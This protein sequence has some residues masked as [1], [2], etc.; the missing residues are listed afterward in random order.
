[1]TDKKSRKLHIPDPGRSRGQGLIE[2]ALLLPVLLI[3][4]SGMV[5]LGFLL[6]E[7]M[8]LQDAARNAA[9][10]ASDSVYYQSDNVQNCDLTEDFYRQTACLVN[11]EL[12]Q[13]KP[14]IGLDINNGVDDVIISAF[15]VEK[16]DAAGDTGNPRRFP[17]QTTVGGYIQGGEAGWSMALDNAAYRQRN[18]SSRFG[19]ADIQDK[20]MAGVPN[21]G[22]VLVEVFYQY[23]HKLGLPWITAFLDNPLTLHIYAVMPLVSAEP[24]PTPGP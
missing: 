6:N 24:T 9:R 19:N 18:Q 8:A 21:T 23:H 2:T 5:E 7:Y 14:V 1:M 16:I 4:L 11:R 20:L 22:W 10:F 15:S 17:Y 13:E 3:V 12:S